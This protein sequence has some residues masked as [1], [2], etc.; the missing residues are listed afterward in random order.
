[1]KN[2]L[3]LSLLLLAFLAQ[4]Q[5][6]QVTS[7]GIKRIENFPSQFVDARNVDIWLP[8]GYSDKE[9]YA[10]LYMH[11]GQMLYDAATTWNK[12][13]WEVDETAGKLIAE[14]KTQKFIVVGV[15]N[16]GKMR[17]PEYFPQKP[18]EA[19][20]QAERDTVT[21][22]L[23]RMARIKG[24]FKPISDLY[25]QFLVKELKPYVDTHFATKKDKKHTFVAGS[26]M[27]GLISMYAICEYPKVFGGAACFSTHWPGTIQKENNPVPDAFLTYMKTHLPKAKNHKIYFD[28]GDQTLDAMYP[29]LQKKVDE[30]MQNKGF[31]AKNWTTIF[32]AGDDHSETAWGKRLGVALVFLLKN[33]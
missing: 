8:E 29:P 31:S 24:I 9:K 14:G 13:A 25:L 22:V 17:H 7:G 21:A 18:Y 32:A 23:Q 10:V 26:S 3:L 4:A 19:M 12:Q 16:N 2:T 5:I 1:M 30:L 20:T 15:W 33:K 11:D 6:P 27:G 28:Y